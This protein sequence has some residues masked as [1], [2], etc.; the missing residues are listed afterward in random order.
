MASI[1]GAPSED[2]RVERRADGWYVRCGGQT[3]GPY[4]SRPESVNRGEVPIQ[5]GFVES[6]P[7]RPSPTG[8]AVWETWAAGGQ[9]FM[10]LH[11][12]YHNHAGDKMYDRSRF[13]EATS[14]GS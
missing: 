12:Y 8:T 4:G 7:P 13:L 2:V 9:Q 6:G 1:E 10:I 14:D 3:K 11:S 5:V